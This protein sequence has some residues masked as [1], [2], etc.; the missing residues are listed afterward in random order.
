[1]L[2]EHG[3]LEAESHGAALTCIDGN[4]AIPAWEVRRLFD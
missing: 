1:M 2:A 3:I 4:T